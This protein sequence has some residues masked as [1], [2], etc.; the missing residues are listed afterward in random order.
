MF[1]PPPIRKVF[2]GGTR[3]YKIYA[4]FNRQS[5]SPFDDDRTAPDT[6]AKGSRF[7]TLTTTIWSRS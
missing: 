3:R 6:S 2:E 5:E 4:L 7:W 1:N